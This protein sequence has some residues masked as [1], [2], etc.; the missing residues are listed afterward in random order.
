MVPLPPDET[1]T[2]RANVAVPPV[3]CRVDVLLIATADVPSPSDC[4]VP[5]AENDVTTKVPPETE[6]VPV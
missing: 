2:S 4:G 1:V 6:V 5:L 3:Y